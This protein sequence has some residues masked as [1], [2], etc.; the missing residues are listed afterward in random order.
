MCTKYTNKRCTMNKLA[1]DR[2][3]DRLSFPFEN[4]SREPFRADKL[5][6]SN[7][8]IYQD[9]LI[10]NACALPDEKLLFDECTFA[11]RDDAHGEIKIS[12]IYNLAAV[13]IKNGG[14]KSGFGF[15]KLVL[16]SDAVFSSG[17][18]VHSEAVMVE[19]VPFVSVSEDY[20]QVAFTCSDGLVLTIDTNIAS[21]SPLDSRDRNAWARGV[22]SIRTS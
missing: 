18:L 15:S 5:V 6:L 19:G 17:R 14:L 21:V 7:N 12:H 10:W 22:R 4:I 1:A 9:V 8:A 16:C 11:F 13:I 3:K 2:F 20:S